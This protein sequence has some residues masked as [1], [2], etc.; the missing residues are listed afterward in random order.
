MTA[1]ID[2]F[3]S[4]PLLALVAF[5]R[6]RPLTCVAVLVGLF[7]VGNMSYLLVAATAKTG[8]DSAARKT[9]ALLAKGWARLTLVYV[10]MLLGFPLVG[11]ALA[12]WWLLDV[13]WPDRGAKSK[14]SSE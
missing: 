4:G 14:G 3:I 12:A 2:K 5:I 13:L 7:F 8:D 1:S 10:L 9:A 6:R 11:W